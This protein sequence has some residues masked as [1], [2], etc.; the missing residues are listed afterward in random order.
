MKKMSLLPFW[1]RVHHLV[2]ILNKF[3]NAFLICTTFRHTFLAVINQLIVNVQYLFSTR[4]QGRQKSGTLKL[5]YVTFGMVLYV[6]I[7]LY[8]MLRI[9]VC[10]ICYKWQFVLR[11]VIHIILR[12]YNTYVSYANS[13][14]LLLMLCG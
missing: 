9:I 7:F 13:Y 8:D 11:P 2:S 3:S 5:V 14:L 4:T 1:F 10:M 6:Y 12:I